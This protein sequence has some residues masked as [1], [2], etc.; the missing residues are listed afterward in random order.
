METIKIREYQITIEPDMANF[1]FSGQAQLHFHAADPIE[2]ITLNALELEVLSCSLVTGDDLSPCVFR[3]DL[4][5]ETL[6]IRLPQHRTGPVTLMLEYRGAI[7]D[8][9]AGFYRSSYKVGDETRY[10]AVTQ[11]QES[12]ARRAFPCMDHPLHKATFAIEMIVDEHLAVVSNTSI[13]ETILRGDGKKLV[14]FERTPEMSTYLVF[15]GI[16]DF[17]IHADEADRRVRSVTLPGLQP[18]ARFGLEFARKTLLFCETYYG[19]GYPLSKLDL[20]AIPD[21]AFGAMENWGAMTFR[22]NLLLHYPGTTS[23]SGETRICEV[24][25]H[26]IAHQWFGNLVTPS[27]WKYLWL[28]ESFATYFGFGVV[29]HFHPEWATW[30][31]F[32]RSQT[33]SALNR[34]GLC[35]TFPIEIPGGEHVVINTGTAPIIYSKGGSILRQIEGYIGKEAFQ[36]GLHRYLK[37]HAYACAESHHLWEALEA[38]S[39]KPVS[40]IMKSWIEQRG[41]PVVEAARKKDGL[42]LTQRR[43]TYLPDHSDQRWMIPVT[44]RVYDPDG[45]AREISVLMENRE[46][47]VD[48]GSRTSAYVVNA[49]RSGFFRTRYMDESTLNELAGLVKEKRL[50]AVERWGLEND[51]YALVR[52]G[53]VSLG[54]H[55]EFLAHYCHEDALLPLSGIGDNL[56]HAR[57]IMGDGFAATLSLRADSIFKNVFSRI[58]Y[59]PLRDEPYAVSILRDQLIWQAAVFGDRETLDVAGNAFLRLK[60]GESIHPDILKSTLQVGAFSGNTDVF[61]WMERRFR[62]AVSEHERQ[63]ILIAMGCF[64]DRRVIEKVGAYV[65]ENVP[66]RNRF[67]PIASMAA[68]PAAVPG[69]WDWY[70]SHVEMLEHSHPLLYERVIAAIVP[71][72]GMGKVD[73]VKKFFEGYTPKKPMIREVVGISLEKLSINTRM[74]DLNL[75]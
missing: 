68:N 15:F 52:K 54:T 43:F 57:L 8:K 60:N 73:A 10:I 36:K 65:L 66:D 75:A 48:I 33:E 40:A 42:H 51:L 2:E 12:D 13:S 72:C 28:N 34:D 70:V 61:D 5:K 23:R 32:M 59:D 38:A 46:T 37:T 29:D 64:Q 6:R 22:E 39:D 4:A 50:P 30:E 20:L 27:D 56:F 44:V 21:F 47:V 7:N 24:I 14:R 67:I 41:F 58:G 74:H 71:V 3:V 53:D 25:A 11:F 1:T 49:G 26:E 31:R 16:G 69:M 62:Q 17:E 63:N 45:D 35:E 55:L 19:I 9:M 18:H